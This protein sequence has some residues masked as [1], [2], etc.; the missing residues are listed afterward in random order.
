MKRKLLDLGTYNEY[1]ILIEGESSNENR[2]FKSK[3]SERIRHEY[4]LIRLRR[5][6]IWSEY[7]EAEK[8][9]S[10]LK[11]I[12]FKSSVI[13]KKN[14][15]KHIQIIVKSNLNFH[16]AQRVKND[17]SSQLE[18]GENSFYIFVENDFSKSSNHV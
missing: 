16:E 7:E 3:F 17:L 14:A 5:V 13:E 18:N 10:Y 15:S 8:A 12:G 9:L 4:S 6:F 2:K 11:N 1:V